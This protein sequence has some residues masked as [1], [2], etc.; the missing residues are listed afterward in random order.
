[1]IIRIRTNVGQWRVS[2]LTPTSLG[3][4]IL[5][6]IASTRGHT[7]IYTQPLSLDPAGHQPLNLEQSLQEQN[8]T[9]GSMIY[10]RVDP[11]SVVAAA[12]GGA[13]EFDATNNHNNG[14]HP[15]NV[16]DSVTVPTETVTKPTVQTKR[17][18]LPDGSISIIE[19]EEGDV[20]ADAK[21]FRKG[22]LPLRSMK[23]QWTLQE[24]VEMDN[25][26]VFK[27]QQQKERWVGSGGVSL[28]Q[29]SAQDFQSYLTTFAFQRQRFG[30]LY[31]KFIDEE[32]DP[33]EVVDSRPKKETLFGTELPDTEI[34]YTA[35]NKM[36]LV[37]AIY[38]PPQEANPDSA[39]GFIA[40]EDPTEE[41]VNQLASMLGLKRVGWIFGHPPRE[42]GFQMSSAEV[43]MAAEL[44]IEAADGVEETPFVT[45]KVTVGDDGNVSF[46][47]FQVSK[48][49]MEMVAEE[50]LEVG[51]NPG[52]CNVNETFTAIQEG[53][54]S[55]TV[56]NN[57]F[58]TVVPIQQHTSE[59]L[60]SDFP[61]ANR[62]HDV[63]Q[64]THDEMKKQLQKSGSAG[65]T[66][67]D[68]LADFNL[69]IYLSKFLDME[70][71]L[72]KICQS[73]VDR[74]VPL[75]DG[76]KLIIASMA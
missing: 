24:F 62:D 63:R 40:L 22:M 35:K 76:Y 1:M 14:N 37:E 5:S 7:I 42:A 56:D 51:E 67:V 6:E 52:F 57:F 49:C 8:L 48:Q 70:T 72:V 13:G 2:S 17:R 31:G 73:I 59:M 50:A 18:I 58:L 4:D 27:I 43:I 45:V 44:Q 75:D 32:P 16:N 69:L 3:Q 19:V 47:A 64:Q 65:W 26:F 55:R 30:Y 68:L 61:K 21:S 46:E 29:Q 23:M 66:F 15:A 34:K 38:E 33:Q 41:K 28:D 39:E 71:D 11:S 9:H 12:G 25:K 10:C 54:E 60:V 36:V 53:K 20:N 74:D